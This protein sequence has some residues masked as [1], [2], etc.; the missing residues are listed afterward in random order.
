M[1][2]SIGI[3][4]LYQYSA[5]VFVLSTV[6]ISN[7][8][9]FLLRQLTWSVPIAGGHNCLT[10]V[11]HLIFN[12]YIKHKLTHRWFLI[13]HIFNSTQKEHSI[14]LSFFRD[15]ITIPLIKII[16]NKERSP[17]RKR[18]SDYQYNNY[19]T[20]L[21]TSPTRFP[22]CLRLHSASTM[23]KSLLLIVFRYVLEY[24]FY[25]TIFHIAVL[26]NILYSKHDMR[27]HILYPKFFKEKCY[28]CIC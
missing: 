15:Y 8:T 4:H 12:F 14:V 17:L 7:S 20:G 5:S 25:Q 18:I 22:V 9:Q 27:H 6:P 21:P 1:S 3:L 26:H 2:K 28:F 16:M 11:N 24:S 13:F 19:I 23:F 10:K